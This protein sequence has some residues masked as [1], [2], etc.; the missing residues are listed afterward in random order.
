MGLGW[1]T[2]LK[3]LQEERHLEI[4]LK[5]Y[6]TKENVIIVYIANHYEQH[7]PPIYLKIMI[8]WPDE[9][10]EQYKN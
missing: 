7:C 6:Y 8:Y 4:L 2:I 3:M 1:R 10:R 5:S 9:V